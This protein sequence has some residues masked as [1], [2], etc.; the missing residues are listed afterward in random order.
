M[1]NPEKI[2]EKLK[3]KIT[4]LK[5]KHGG[6]LHLLVAAGEYCIATTPSPA[7]YQQFKDYAADDR[8]RTH[9][10]ETLTRACVVYPDPAGLDVLL[11]RKP[12]LATSFGGKL[13]E[14]AGAVEEV[15]A[16]KL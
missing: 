3:D 6:E 10:L 15:E 7:Q 9:A 16:K 8:K 5:S 2:A 4:E 12:G 13:T 14:L 11:E 1:N